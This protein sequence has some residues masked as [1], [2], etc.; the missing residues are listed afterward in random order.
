MYRSPLARHDKAGLTTAC[1]PLLCLAALRGR[2]C[3]P[4][5]R[6]LGL[7]RALSCSSPRLPRPGRQASLLFLGS[8]GVGP[9]VALILVRALVPDA[10]TLAQ[11]PVLRALT[12]PS[13]QGGCPRRTAV[14][15]SPAGTA[16]PLA[17]GGALQG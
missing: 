10:P 9:A 11:R 13:S 1:Q 8:G 2:S 12:Y 6:R 3:L 16:G 4:A 5:A 17:P 7:G 14:S 15:P